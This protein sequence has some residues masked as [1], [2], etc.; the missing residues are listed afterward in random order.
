MAE[1]EHGGGEPAIGYLREPRCPATRHRVQNRRVER[2]A[3]NGVPQ[4][5]QVQPTRAAALACDV[6]R[7]WAETRA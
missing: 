6:A 1:L 7:D 3:S 4:C 2:C 5:S